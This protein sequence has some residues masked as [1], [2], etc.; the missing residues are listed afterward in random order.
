MCRYWHYI[1]FIEYVNKM[2]TIIHDRIF[3]IYFIVTLFF[4]IIG[5]GSILGS[6]DP[7]IIIIS[8][9]WLLS[10][11]ALL[12]LIYHAS[13]NWGPVDPNN[14]NLQICFVDNNSKC[15]DA[16]NRV[17]LFVNI[18][19][20]VLIIIS[21]LWAGELR[22]T[23]GGPLRGMSGVFILLGGLILCRLASGPHIYIIPFWVAIGYLLIWFGL[24]LYVVI[25]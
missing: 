16:N 15:F 6:N 21:T 20:I 10:N 5:V 12:I 17:W 4:T 9:L 24:T 14:K 2:Y 3:W 13:I 25:N 22:N 1:H 8:I 18:L 7:H 23:N 19:F 11:V